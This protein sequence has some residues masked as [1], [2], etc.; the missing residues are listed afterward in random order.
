MYIV[1]HNVWNVVSVYCMMN[2]NVWNVVSVYCM[3][4]IFLCIVC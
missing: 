1:N 3:T 2:H 4:R